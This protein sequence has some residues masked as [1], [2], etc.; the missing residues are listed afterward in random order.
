MRIIPTILTFSIGCSMLTACG[1][2]RE[3]VPT[4]GAEAPEVTSEFKT[5][6]LKTGKSD[7]I[8]LQT[9]NYTVVIDAGEKSDGKKVIS[10]LEESGTEKID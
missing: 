2:N 3:T 8:L 9:E 1:T 10:R 4:S 7:A 5:E 6:I